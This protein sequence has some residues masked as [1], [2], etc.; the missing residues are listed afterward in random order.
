MSTQ[1]TVPNSSLYDVVTFDILVDGELMNPAYQ[2]L[3][4]LIIK[5]ANRVPTARIELRDGDASLETFEISNTDLF[6]PGKE[7]QVKLGR[8]RENTQVFKGIITQ[9]RIKIRQDGRASL[10]VEC[11]DASV[12]MT[13]G[14]HSKYF[15]EQTDS[16]VIESLISAY[17]GL[18]PEVEATSH[19]HKELVQHHA[20]DWDFM[21][22]RADVNSM[23]VLV[24]DGTVQVKKPDSSAEPA[25]S[26][27]YGGTIHEFEAVMDAR[28]QWAAANAKSWDYAG[29]Q[30]FESESGSADFGEHGNISGSNLSDTIG[31][32]KFELRHSGHLLA[33]ELEA[34]AKAC[35]L[36]SRLA[37]IRGWGKVVIGYAP[38]K[39]GDTVELAGVG[40]RFNGNAYVT[41][42]R[43]E[44]GAG[45]WHTYIQFGLSPDWFA[46]REEVID[47]PAAGVL[48]AV[49]GLQIG[50][51]VQLQDDPDGEDRI[52]V[53]LPIIDNEATGIWSRVCTLDAGTERGSFYRPEIDDEVIVG[54]LNGDPRDAVVLGM[55][56]S[57]AKPAPIPGS[58]D[59][60]EKGFV[61][62][63]KMRI[64]FDDDKKIITIDTPAG[65]SMVFS[66][67]D[68]AITITD[69]NGNNIT[70]D[71][72][73]ITIKSIA[74]ITI[75]APGKIDIKASQ[76]LSMEG[77]NVEGKANVNMKMAGTAAAEFSASG[78]TTVKGATVMIN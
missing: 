44:V 14:R 28:A 2:V 59:N 3:N 46:S 33:E 26:L 32:E 29:Q 51:V 18:T 1:R 43:H 65:N 12:K 4:I 78:S 20:T 52:L 50:K 75:E 72:N 48:P 39:P 62:R 23:L 49:H 7:I 63:S 31:L 25:L 16:Q 57:S 21:L 19:M 54:F 34:W 30:L 53:K 74:D 17:S 41:A 64:W 69:Q 13:I 38:I 10:W 47:F 9:Q 24:D 6:V 27:S 42:V 73:G 71:P 60:H 58:D 66:E 8:D 77:L 36:K 56:H 76:D 35:M 5:E 37:K 45:A 40:N 61:T 11:K 68:T 67:E 15:E 55:L 70:M 22:S